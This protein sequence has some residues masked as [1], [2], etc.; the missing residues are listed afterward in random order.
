MAPQRPQPRNKLQEWFAN[1]RL[2]VIM[3]APMLGTSN[4]TLAAH[5][6]KTGGFGFVPGCYSFEPGS[7][8]L[9]VL[10]KELE[11]ARS[12]LGLTEL[13]LTP[14]PVGVGFLTLHPS[15]KHF[16][17]TAL[18]I[19]EKHM[20]QAVWLFAP[21]P[22]AS[23][24]AHP[25]IIDACHDHGLKVFVQVGTVAAAREAAQDGAD[26]I[27][28]QGVD[29]G[30]HQW[31]HGASVI[32]LVPEV[33][34][35]LREEFAGREIA[36]VAA[37]GISHESSVVAAVALGELIAN[38]AWQ[39]LPAKESN[40]SEAKKKAVLETRDGGASTTAG[41][42]TFHDD[43]QG[44][45]IWPA[46]YDGRAIVTDSYKDHSSG[47]AIEENIEK[48]R[49]ANEAGDSSRQIT[50]LGTGVGLVKD[51]IPAA[52]IVRNLREGAKRRLEDMR[53]AFDDEGEQEK[54]RPWL[55]QL[56]H[57]LYKHK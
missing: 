18:P 56:G 6:S 3:S 51:A 24:R 12:V 36:L 27:I 42:S 10:E 33:Q 5:V 9:V 47:L 21:D 37:G 4:G 15:V 54:D 16:R 19:L 8:D 7:S 23:T 43:V 17:E 55:K 35:M 52:D 1:T 26:G 41:R 29:A 50:W 40:F 39:F 49:A 2:P 38:H 25:D 28:A 48:L 22:T 13:T 11:T 14:M 32:S 53:F 31:A 46:L 57:T 45:K 44:S 30:G 20:P 34:M